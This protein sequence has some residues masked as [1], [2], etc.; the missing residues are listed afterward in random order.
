MEIHTQLRLSNDA[1]RIAD[2][3][4]SWSVWLEG[5]DNALDQVTSVR[6]MLHPTFS[7]PIRV[8]NDRA[9][10][11]RLDAVGWGEFAIAARITSKQGKALRLERWVEFGAATEGAHPRRP[12]V[13][14]SF[15]ST[16]KPMIQP[17]LQNLK[18]QGVQVLSADQMRPGELFSSQMNEMLSRAD[19]FALIAS[20]ELSPF[21]EVELEQAITHKKP[22][23]P[24]L[25]GPSASLP[26]PI[27]HIEASRLESPQ[28][29]EAI[30]DMLAARA[31][32][33]LSNDFIDAI[34]TYIEA[35]EKIG[36]NL[37][38]LPSSVTTIPSP[39]SSQNDLPEEHEANPNNSIWESRLDDLAEIF[40]SEIRLLR[41]EMQNLGK[42]I[43]LNSQI[44]DRKLDAL[45]K[46]KAAQRVPLSR[47]GENWMM[48]WAANSMT[49]LKR[50]QFNA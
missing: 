31:K 33:T 48:Q 11:F 34:E 16:D 6:Y 22:V 44:L 17:L 23:I 36:S 9:S 24:I 43:E 13:F 14:L 20:G 41:K 37:Q 27:S 47:S 4:W 7:D 30:A 42:K 18:A 8:S 25:V 39:G 1:T 46:P 3:C 32:D 26:P 49:Q 38:L 15:R 12:C 50:D 21:A 10:K 35:D 28:H 2:D 19:V 29:P 40:K 45:P 5:P